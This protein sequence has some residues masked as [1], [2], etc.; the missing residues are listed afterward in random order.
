MDSVVTD[1]QRMLLD[2]SVRF[3]EE[4]YP[5]ERVR[6][7][8]YADAATRAEYVRATA[9]LGWYSMLV[10]ER[11]GGGSVTANGLVDAA[12]IAA[13]RGAGLQPGPFVANNV[14]GD[15]L[16]EAD[17]DR[18]AKVVQQLVSGEAAAAW[19]VG[20]PLVP[21]ASGGRIEATAARDGH[22]IDGVARLVQDAASA[23]WLLVT[24][25]VDGRPAQFLLAADSPGV[26]VTA[27][28]SLDLSRTF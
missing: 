12:L 21:E 27:L 16:A 24:A 15:A 20:A 26:V 3:I 9:A 6:T 28:D 25:D 10:P 14:V 2:T 8:G 11:L 22:R 13:K 1:D 4:T 23:D 7:G 17:G 5:I 18:F 19:A